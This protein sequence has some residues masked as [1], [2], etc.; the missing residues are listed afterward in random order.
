MEAT[1]QYQARFQLGV[2]QRRIANSKND[3]E[4]EAVEGSRKNLLRES[5]ANLKAAC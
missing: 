5:I 1:K 3:E 4:D 2:T